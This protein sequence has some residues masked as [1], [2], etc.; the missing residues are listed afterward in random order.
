M[1]VLKFNPFLLEVIIKNRRNSLQIIFLIDAHLCASVVD[2]FFNNDKP[3]AAPKTT[4]IVRSET[5][6]EM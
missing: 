6:V 2:D 4:A 3:M 5:G 1:K